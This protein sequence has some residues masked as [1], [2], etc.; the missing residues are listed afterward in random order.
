M[1]LGVSME[2]SSETLITNKSRR[3][4]TIFAFTAA[5][6]LS[7]ILTVAAVIYLDPVDP[8][9]GIYSALPLPSLS[10]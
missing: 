6:M 4:G 9:V 7:G 5:G 2:M 10:L 1:G 8:F 3:F